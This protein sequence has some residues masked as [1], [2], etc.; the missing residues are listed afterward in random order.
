[1]VSISL[2]VD[3]FTSTKLVRIAMTQVLRVSFSGFKLL[4]FFPFNT[5]LKLYRIIRQVTT[6]FKKII[7]LKSSLFKGN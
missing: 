1:M 7:C 6:F 4:L 3:S 5:N 2:I